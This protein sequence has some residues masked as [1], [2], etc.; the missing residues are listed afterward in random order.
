MN[1]SYALQTRSRRSSNDRC[2]SWLTPK[3]HTV[4]VLRNDIE[5][6]KTGYLSICRVA[7]PPSDPRMSFLYTSCAS[8]TTSARFKAFFRY[9][10]DILHNTEARAIS[11][12]QVEESPV[13]GSIYDFYTV[14]VRIVHRTTYHTFTFFSHV[15]YIDNMAWMVKRGGKKVP[16]NR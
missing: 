3:V 5:I 15:S 7:K 16:R 2:G 12:L 6:H 1:S 14:P 9:I 8:T 11:S 4:D 13:I 10:G